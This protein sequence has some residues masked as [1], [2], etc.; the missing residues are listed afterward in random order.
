MISICHM[1]ATS[2]IG[3]TPPEGNTVCRVTGIRPIHM[4]DSIERRLTFADP[5]PYLLHEPSPYMGGRER[6]APRG[7]GVTPTKC[8][9]PLVAYCAV[10]CLDVDLGPRVR[11]LVLLLLL[12]RRP[13]SSWLPRWRGRKRV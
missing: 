1:G 2:D 9:R 7:R 5:R 11:P 8:R 12:R 4:G 3:A 10:P 13:L 6:P